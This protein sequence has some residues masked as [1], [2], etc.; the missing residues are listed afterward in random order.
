MDEGLGPRLIGFAILYAV[1]LIAMYW[2]LRL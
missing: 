2:A 1:Y